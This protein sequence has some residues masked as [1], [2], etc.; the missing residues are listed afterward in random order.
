MALSLV[1][2]LTAGLFLIL[3]PWKLHSDV[4]ASPDLKLIWSNTS[5]TP[6]VL[7]V[8]A[9]DAMTLAVAGCVEVESASVWLLMMTD[10]WR[11]TVIFSNSERPPTRSHNSREWDYPQLHSKLLY[12]G[13]LLLR[14]FWSFSW[15]H[16]WLSCGCSANFYGNQAT[17]QS[18]AFIFY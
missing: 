3:I 5:T 12:P 2:S 17:I 10:W 18:F 1:G 16:M 4:W 9:F 6:G 11:R 13:S 15:K 14:Q 7:A 8:K